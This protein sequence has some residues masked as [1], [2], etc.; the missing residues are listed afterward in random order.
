LLHFQSSQCSCEQSPPPPFQ[1]KSS[2]TFSK[3]KIGGM[4]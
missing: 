3:T 2:F 4:I 1:Q